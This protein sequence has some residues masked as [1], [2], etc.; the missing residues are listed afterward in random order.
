MPSTADLYSIIVIMDCL[1]CIYLVDSI[2]TVTKGKEAQFLHQ[3]VR[4]GRMLA[5]NV[6]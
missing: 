4:S 3:I 2:R 5:V 6:V 1:D